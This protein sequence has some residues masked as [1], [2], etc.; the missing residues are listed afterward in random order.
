[1]SLGAGIYD[2]LSG[3]LSVGDNVFPL[4]L[5]QS[6]TL[7]AMTYQLVSETPTVT[8]DWQQDHPLYDGRRYEEA[9]VQFNAY[10]RTFDEAE[11][12]SDEL[13]AAITGYR[14]PWG[15]V[16]IESVLPALSLD[17]FEPETRNWRRITDYFIQWIGGG[18]GS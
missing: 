10:G 18:N 8:H 5:P 16:Q 2:F 13:K 17:D 7:P 12:L 14:G 1:M 4:T 3:E 9:R 11:A 15:D 6:V